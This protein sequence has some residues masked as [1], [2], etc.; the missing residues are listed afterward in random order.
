MYSRLENVPPEIHWMIFDFLAPLDLLVAFDKID[1]PVHDALCSYRGIHLNFLSMK[2][3]S[4]N[5]LCEHIQGSSIQSIVLSDGEESPGQIQSFLSRMRHA[6]FPHLRSVIARQ[7]RDK[8]T[9]HSLLDRLEGNLSIETLEIDTQLVRLNKRHCRSIASTLSSLSSLR[10][11][12]VTCSDVLLHLCEPLPRMRHLTIKSC[13]LADLQIIYRWM[14]NLV[15][16]DLSVPLNARQETLVDT[17]SRVRCL[18][19]YSRSDMSFSD[20]ENLLVCHPLVERLVLDIGHHEDL[21]H[22]EQWQALIERRLPCLK[23]IDLNIHPEENSLAVDLVLVPFQNTFWTQDKRCSMVSFVSTSAWMCARLYSVPYFTPGQEWFPPSEG[24][25]YHSVFPY[26]IADH[27]TYLHISQL[28]STTVIPRASFKH[29][30]ILS[31]D[32]DSIDV[33]QL[34]Q[35]VLVSTVRHLKVSKDVRSFAFVP[36]FAQARYIQQL[37]IP[38]GAL[39]HMIDAFINSRQICVQ[40]RKLCVEDSSDQMDLDRF[41]HVFGGLQ[42][43]SLFIVDRND[44]LRLIDGLAHLISATFRWTQEHALDARVSKDWLDERQLG[45]DG[46]FSLGYRAFSLW[47]DR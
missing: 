18:K 9:V 39:K 38:S 41:C 44:V 12:S 45:V 4:F 15:H 31:L 32:N 1:G 20:V 43:I 13:A 37:T 21:L 7:C 46:T 24:F 40:I 28:L 29:V 22:G 27:C 10:R 11:L 16:V 3:S 35:L 33:N 42:H 6:E 26:E 34:L 30:E 5:F 2:K 25:I 8:L 36:L 14:V 23:R 17:S 19:V 47:I